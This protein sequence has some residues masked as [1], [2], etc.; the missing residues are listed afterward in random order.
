MSNLGL[1]LNIKLQTLK[2][3]NKA[4]A[5]KYLGTPIKLLKTLLHVADNLG[6]LFLISWFRNLFLVFFS[7]RLVSLK[8]TLN[9]MWS[10]DTCGEKKCKNKIKD[11]KVE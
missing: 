1:Y 8:K 5:L 2:L 10:V 7:S 6:H 4:E 9:F 11:W 3:A